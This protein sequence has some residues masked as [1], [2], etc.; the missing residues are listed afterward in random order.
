MRRFTSIKENR[1]FMFLYRRGKSLDADCIIMYFRKNRNKG[2][3]L[4]ITVTKKLGKA[5]IRNRIRRRIRESFSANSSGISPCYDIIFVA[6][7]KAAK[8]SYAE[9][10]SAMRYLLHKAELI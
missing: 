1:E 10:N 7:S 6:R 4:G 9:I 3:R 2:L 8:V 5:V